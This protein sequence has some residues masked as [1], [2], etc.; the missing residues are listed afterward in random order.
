[1]T[2]ERDMI[3]KLLTQLENQQQL[4]KSTI[5]HTESEMGDLTI[6]N[7]SKHLSDLS[8]LR[9]Y[10]GYLEAVESMIKQLKE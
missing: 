3:N 4:M 8:N 7:L 2:S 9:W 5:A 1:M 10:Q 6:T